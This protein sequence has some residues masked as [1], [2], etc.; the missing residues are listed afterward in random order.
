MKILFKILTLIILAGLSFS[1]SDEESNSAK[2][3]FSRSI[4]IL[5][6]SGELN[7]ELRAT[8]APSSDINIPVEISGSAV[9]DSDYTIS[10][11][12]FILKAGETKAFITLMPK[13]NL[14]ADREIKLA[15]TPVKGYDLGN[16]KWLSFL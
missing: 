10:A 6:S 9:L 1:C 3:A 12:E 2:L 4:Y 5:P 14:T 15:I 11:K 8:M 13:N 16:K 7:V